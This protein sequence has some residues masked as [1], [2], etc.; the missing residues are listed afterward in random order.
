MHLYNLHCFFVILNT[1][2]CFNFTRDILSILDPE[3]TRPFEI[4]KHGWQY[5][6][7]MGPIKAWN[8]DKNQMRLHQD[9][10]EW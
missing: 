1:F 5:N 4:S 2:T 10:G 3:Y 7:N 9:R 6:T 8:G